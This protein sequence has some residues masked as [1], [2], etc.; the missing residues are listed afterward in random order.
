MA[1]YQSFRW[2]QRFLQDMTYRTGFQT[3][4]QA[5]S[6]D[7]FVVEFNEKRSQFRRKIPLGQFQE[8]HRIRKPYGD[9]VYKS[10]HKLRPELK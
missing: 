9:L 7:R 1:I 5:T 2:F 6:S 3:R 10:Y 8:Y 4:W